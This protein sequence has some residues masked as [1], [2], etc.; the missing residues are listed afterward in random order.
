MR[1]ALAGL[2]AILLVTGTA[3]AQS[4]ITP[5]GPP[6]VQAPAS[7]FSPGVY[8]IVFKIPLDKAGKAT[9]ADVEKIIAMTG[10]KSGEISATLP[11]GFLKAARTKFAQMKFTE[12]GAAYR[13]LVFN[14]AEPDRID[15]G[16]D[17][18]TQH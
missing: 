17:P 14:P 5:L 9:G 2:A 15:I 13:F 3:V 8:G 4:A 12:T 7:T 11:D 6:P 1:T 16:P 10:E 18:A